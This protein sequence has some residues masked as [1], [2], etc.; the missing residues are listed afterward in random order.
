[1]VDR[2]LRGVDRLPGP[3][4]AWFFVGG[5]VLA[6]L[7]H[8]ALWLSGTT[9]FGQLNQEVLT[10]SLLAGSLLGLSA[11]MKRTA[12]VAF[13]DFRPALADPSREDAER[14][15]L[16]SIP[17][18]AAIVG[19]VSV[20]VLTDTLYLLYVKPTIAPRPVTA[21]LVVAGA[22]LVFSLVLGLV[23][24]QTL[25]QLRSVRHLNEIAR[26]I[27]VLNSGPVDALS[28]VTAVGAAGMLAL[29]AAANVGVPAT[30]SAFIALDV[31]VIVFAL[32]AFLLPLQVMHRRLSRQK[33]DLLAASA[34]RLKGVLDTLHRAL[35]GHDF[36]MADAL[37]KMV[38]TSIAERDL[39]T[40]LPTW[41]WTTTTIRG[42][43]S[44]LL[45]PVAIFVITRS[46]DRLI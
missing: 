32:S 12:D 23:I 35:D 5:C 16:L 3:A 24:A 6:L 41:P 21:E 14:Q 38:A 27:D 33:A 30:A 4:E 46:I 45:L 37:N 11:F 20:A 34:E 29:I 19:A 15:R 13:E 9:G 18:R 8:A 31:L 42:F 40:R 22:W 17:D 28:R 1:M 39:L 2:A 36:T 26:N 25:I 7:A 44:A 43:T 10:A